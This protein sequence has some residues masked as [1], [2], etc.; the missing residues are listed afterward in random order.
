ML[1]ESSEPS[2][3]EEKEK[4]KKIARCEK[5]NEFSGKS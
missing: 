3:R 5:E 2:R 1:I 4:K